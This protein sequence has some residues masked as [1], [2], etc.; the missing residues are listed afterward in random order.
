[1]PSWLIVTAVTVGYLLV[2]LLVGVLS[3]RRASA[4]TVGYV[5]ADRAFGFL[6]M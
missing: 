3:G 6:V 1:M 2:S 5:A 4:S